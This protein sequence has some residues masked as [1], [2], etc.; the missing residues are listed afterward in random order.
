MRGTS[1]SQKL[2]GL[3][4]NF[5]MCLCVHRWCALKRHSVHKF[6][7]VRCWSTDECRV[8]TMHSS[9]CICVFMC[10]FII[11]THVWTEDMYGEVCL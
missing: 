8:G 4:V 2:C 7:R 10:V 1:A 5:L 9:L 6:E 11:Y 3:L